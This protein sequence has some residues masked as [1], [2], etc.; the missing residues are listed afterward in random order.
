MSG[1]KLDTPKEM[2]KFDVLKQT[3]EEI[4]ARAEYSN[5]LIL[6]FK[7]T[8]EGVTISSNYVKVLQSDGSLGFDMSTL[9]SQFED[10]I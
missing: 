3:P 8:V 2:P 5:G 9:D 1:F 7:N 10:L 6:I 4:I